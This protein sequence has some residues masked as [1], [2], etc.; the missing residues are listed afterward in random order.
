MTLK[1]SQHAQHINDRKNFDEFKYQARIKELEKRNE[2]LTKRNSSLVDT[3]RK[4]IS[5]SQKEK[6]CKIIL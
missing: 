3:Y 6:N 5:S 1:N 4:S 2:V